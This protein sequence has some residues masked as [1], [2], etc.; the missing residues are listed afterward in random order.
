MTVIHED[1]PD[2]Y[3]VRATLPTQ[4]SARTLTIDAA[5]HRV[6]LAAAA[7]EPAPAQ[8]A[9]QPRVRPTMKPDTFAILIVAPTH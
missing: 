1:T 2:R 6:F 8:A 3:T 5:S 9:S 4:K 7:F